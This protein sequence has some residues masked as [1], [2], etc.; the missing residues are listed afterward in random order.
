MRVVVCPDKFAGTLTA[1]QAAAAIAEGWTRQA[2]GDEVIEVPLADGGPGFVDVL[3]AN[4]GGRLVA[5]TVSGP[6]GTQVPATVL[7]VGD[8]GYVEAAQAC[9]LHLL[10]VAE[11]DPGLT[12]TYGVGELLAVA[13][14]QGV[15]RIVVG[16]GGSATNDAGA[17]LLA[18]LGA[19]PAG[20]LRG[21][22]LALTGLTEVDLEP[23]RAALHGVDLVAASD[24][25]NPLLGLRGA[26][27]GFGRQKGADDDLVLALDEALSHFVGLVE[28]EARPM[29]AVAAAS[30]AGAAGG[31]GYALLL[32]GGR[33]EPGIGTV[34]SAVGL[35]EQIAAADLVVTGEGS[36][37]WQSL[38]GKVISG[39][40]EMGVAAARP[41]VA[42]AGQVQVGR[43][44]L[45]ALG[46]ESAYPVAST[47]EQRAA[48]MA[49]PAQMLADLAARV[50]RTWSH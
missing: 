18:A 28:P 41:V 40:A 38:H 49:Q 1:A 8:T 23:A 27:H 19:E 14:E 50:A 26:S 3:H 46:V 17:G 47:P 39:V 9:G 43:R 11:R 12:T 31:L 10:T 34:L 13:I 5:A 7:V 6:R 44:E 48:S 4:L 32:L 25:D 24:V 20:P 42:L 33:R 29:R 22:G 30:G 35:A 15:R 2:P 16:L 36:L 21:G 45:A 37:D